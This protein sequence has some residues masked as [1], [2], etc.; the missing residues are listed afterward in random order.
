LALLGGLGRLRELDI[1]MKSASDVST[2]L[3]NPEQWRSF[4]VGLPRLVILR[5]PTTVEVPGTDALRLVGKHCPNLRRLHL[6]VKVD[7]DRL[8]GND[9]GPLFPHLHT[10]IIRALQLDGIPRFVNSTFVAPESF[11]DALVQVY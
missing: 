7:I 10:L 5:L 3:I 9:K 1:S 4:V 2:T 11:S 8:S 6:N